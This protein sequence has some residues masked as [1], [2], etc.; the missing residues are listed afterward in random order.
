D[1][2][3]SFSPGE[4]LGSRSDEVSKAAANVALPTLILTPENE[5]SRAEPILR[6]LSGEHKDL[7]IPDRAV[8]GSSML[9]PDSNEAASDI[10]PQVEAFLVQF[11]SS[12][13]RARR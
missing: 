3:L 6:A 1:G 10:W 2:I 11:G 8:H 7:V 12:S 13:A 5:R 4:Y 9:I